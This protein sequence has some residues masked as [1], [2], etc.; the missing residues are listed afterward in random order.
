MLS[1]VDWAD[2]VVGHAT[3][4]GDRFLDQVPPENADAVIDA[5]CAPL[6]LDREEW[7]QM[8]RSNV[9]HEVLRYHDELAYLDEE[10][11]AHAS[12]SNSV[13]SQLV[14]LLDHEDRRAAAGES[15][16]RHG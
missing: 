11:T 15:P 13:R 3:F 6:S 2:V 5:F 14:V 4:S 10:D 9:L 1:L 12:L 7:R 16:P 8:R